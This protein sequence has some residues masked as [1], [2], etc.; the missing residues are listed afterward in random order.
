MGKIVKSTD[1]AGNVSYVEEETTLVDD[2]MGAIMSPMSALS[3]D[4]D[5][6]VS[7]RSAGI[8]AILWGAAGFIG[9]E[10]Y[11]QHRAAAGKDPLVGGAIVVK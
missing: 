11:G 1:A 7:K 2:A 8:G 10:R 5:E 4:G 6:F 3:G 9:G